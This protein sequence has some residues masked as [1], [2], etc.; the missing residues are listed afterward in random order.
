MCLMRRKCNVRA[1]MVS[2]RIR[3][4][5]TGAQQFYFTFKQEKVHPLQGGFFRRKIRSQRRFGLPR[6]SPLVFYPRRMRE[7]IVTHYRLIAYYLFL[8]RIRKK[9]ERDP[10]PY[11]DRALAMPD[12]ESSSPVSALTA[13]SRPAVVA[14]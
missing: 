2:T 9:V 6:E 14:A 8:H 3:Q 12:V 5:R 11:V 7:V 10:L 4:T 13:G 1:V